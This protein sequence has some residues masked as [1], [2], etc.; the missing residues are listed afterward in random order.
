MIDKLTLDTILSEYKFFRRS[1]ILPWMTT[2]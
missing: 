2:L 1:S